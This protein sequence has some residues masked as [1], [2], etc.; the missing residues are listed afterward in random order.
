MEIKLPDEFSRRMKEL[1]GDE[2]EKFIDSYS[3]QINKGIRINTLKCDN[4]ENIASGLGITEKVIWC[5][6]GYL[7]AYDPSWIFTDLYSS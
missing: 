6:D 2:Y 1:T 4:S 7:I 5:D 3:T